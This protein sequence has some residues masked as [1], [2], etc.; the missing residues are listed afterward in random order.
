MSDGERV[1]SVMLANV[2]GIF[3]VTISSSYIWDIPW[4]SPIIDIIALGTAAVL[5]C[6]EA[7]WICWPRRKDS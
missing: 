5:V 3:V 2:A 6:G 1:A 7:V 4:G